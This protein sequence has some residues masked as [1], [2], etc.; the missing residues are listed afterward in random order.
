MKIRL[1]LEI[2]SQLVKYLAGEQALGDFRDWFDASTWD[3]EQS[4]L[5][6]DAFEVAGEIEL[7]F[8]EFSNGHLTETELRKKLLPLARQF[9]E[10]GQ[11]WAMDGIWIRTSSS[12]VTQPAAVALE[13]RAGIT[14][15]V[16]S[17]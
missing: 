8:S 17:L 1:D 10:Q 13:T 12:N 7:R 3:I 2:H 9:S 16:V 15:S 5:S 14:I 11:I 6:Q 4:G